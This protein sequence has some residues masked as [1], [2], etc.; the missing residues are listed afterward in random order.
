[1]PIFTVKAKHFGEV[2]LYVRAKN[3]E[4]ALRKF[5]DGEEDDLEIIDASKCDPIYNTLKK[6]GE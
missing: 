3:E 6:V 4:E 2:I 1:M 5:E